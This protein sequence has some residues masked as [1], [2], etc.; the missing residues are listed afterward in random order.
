[1]GQFS[2]HYIWVLLSHWH[3]ISISVYLSSHPLISLFIPPK[4]PMYQEINIDA[5]NLLTIPPKAI[6]VMN[7]LSITHLLSYVMCVSWIHSHWRCLVKNY[8]HCFIILTCNELLTTRVVEKP[9][10]FFFH[11]YFTKKQWSKLVINLSLECHLCVA[12]AQIVCHLV[13]F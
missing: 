13:G 4:E 11:C 1:M 2:K 5:C 10:Y 7:V 8:I 3:F 12:E 6:V 9:G